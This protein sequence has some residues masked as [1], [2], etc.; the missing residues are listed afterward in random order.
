MDAYLG[1]I[2]IFSGNFAPAGWLLCEGQIL[3]IQMYTALFSLVGTAYGGNGTTN[4]GLPDL[5]GSAPIGQGQGPGLTSRTVGETGGAAAVTLAQN[6]IPVH[7]H[8]ASGVAANGTVNTPA[9]ALWAQFNS[10]G[11]TPTYAKVYGASTDTT[12]GAAALTTAGKGM[13]HNNM[14]PFLAMRFIICIN[15]IFPPRPS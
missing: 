1:E 5:R 10:G 6:D 8:L 12:M 15:G 9:G 4:F 14:Q 7:T 2:R 13:P 3:P 11:R